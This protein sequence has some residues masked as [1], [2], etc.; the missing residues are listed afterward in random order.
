MNHIFILQ[1]NQMVLLDVE[2]A[3]YCTYNPIRRNPSSSGCRPPEMFSFNE[4]PDPRTD[5][6]GI[7]GLLYSLLLGHEIAYEDYPYQ[8]SD[9]PKTIS[10]K[11]RKIIYKCLQADIGKRY[12]IIRD[13]INALEKAKAGV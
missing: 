4:K 9:L 3:I 8:F 5:I 13:L 11:T 6:Y 2:Y 10:L 7:G 12:L 1:D